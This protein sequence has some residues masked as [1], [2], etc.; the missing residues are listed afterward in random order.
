MN[1]FYFSIIDPLPYLP[2]LALKIQSDWRHLILILNFEFDTKSIE[3][4]GRDEQHRASIALK[5]WY[6]E[7]G[8]AASLDKLLQALKEIKRNDIVLFLENKIEERKLNLKG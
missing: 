3:I 2:H 6:E 4:D 7:C 1:S 5:K 8:A